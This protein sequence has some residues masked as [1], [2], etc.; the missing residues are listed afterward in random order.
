MSPVCEARKIH[1]IQTTGRCYLNHKLESLFC[2]NERGKAPKKS[3][4]SQ[5]TN[6]GLFNQGCVISCHRMTKMDDMEINR[7]DILGHTCE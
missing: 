3:Y 2:I 4:I 6:F 7:G 5:R 1:D